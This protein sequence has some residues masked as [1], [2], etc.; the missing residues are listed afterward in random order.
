MAAYR[1]VPPDECTPESRVNWISVGKIS[2]WTQEEEGIVD[3]FTLFLEGG[4]KIYIYFLS[5]TTFRVRFNLDPNAPYVKSRSPATETERIEAHELKVKEEGGGQKIREKM[6]AAM[7]WLNFDNFG[8][9]AP[10]L[11]PEGEVQ[12]PLNPNSP[13]Y[14]SSPFLIEHNPRPDGA[15]AGP[16]YAYGI[17]IDNT[18]QTFVN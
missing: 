2:K 8:Y 12:G 3:K 1:Y 6:G 10:D 13:L 7:T 14:Q 16:S 17:L 18:S 9:T 5:H 11:T 15:F 4:L